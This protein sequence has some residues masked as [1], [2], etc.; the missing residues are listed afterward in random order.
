MVEI[1]VCEKVQIYETALNQLEG[2][3]GGAT[4]YQFKA[5][6]VRR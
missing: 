5:G 3:N 6:A 4:K 2:I 1:R